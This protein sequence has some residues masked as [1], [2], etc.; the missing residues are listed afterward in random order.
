L[1]CLVIEDS[2]LGVQGAVAA[3][4]QC[5]GLDATGDGAQLAAVGAVP[6]RS[7]HQV[8]ALLRAALS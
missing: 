1:A 2:P 3:G 7:M 5:L 4:M 6:I 8:P